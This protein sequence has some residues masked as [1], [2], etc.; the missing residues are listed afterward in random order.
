MGDP[1]PQYQFPCIVPD[2][3]ASNVV[4]LAGVTNN[5]TLE[6]NKVNL[7]NVAA[8]SLK[9][10]AQST[11]T[12]LWARDMALVCD[13]FNGDPY[14]FNGAPIML[15][16]FSGAVEPAAE[17]D[18][19]HT[20]V[21]GPPLVMAVVANNGTFVSTQSVPGPWLIGGGLYSNTG[22][23]GKYIWY[24]GFHNKAQGGRAS[25]WFAIAV[26]DDGSG[27]LYSFQLSMV[28]TTTPLL[29]I[30]TFMASTTLLPA[31]GYLSIFDKKGGGLTYTVSSRA[32]VNN[33]ATDNSIQTLSSPTAIKMNGIM[34]TKDAIPVTMGPKGYIVDKASSGVTI[35]YTIQPSS[36]DIPELQLVNVS[37]NVPPFLRKR[38]STSLGT[39]LVFY[40]GWDEFGSASNNFYVYDT[41]TN[42]WGGQGLVPA[43][44][45]PTNGSGGPG[46]GGDGG[47]TSNPANAGTNLAG[48]IGGSVA[49][50][51]V[52][53]LAF[54]FAIRHRRRYR[55]CLDQQTESAADVSGSSGAGW[56]KGGS[57]RALIYPRSKHRGGRGRARHPQ[58]EHEQEQEQQQQQQEQTDEDEMEFGKVAIQM[59]PVIS[60]PQSLLLQS[61]TLTSNSSL[62]LL[63]TDSSPF[64]PSSLPGPGGRNPQ[65]VLGST[66]LQYEAFFEPRNNP[67]VAIA[68][69]ITTT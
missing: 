58:Q 27:G 41:I 32:A 66:S 56:R 67:Q 55:R 22:A 62:S 10:V 51:V 2:T 24:T 42:S 23:S 36:T 53:A 57:R 18:N 11:N 19:P 13:I 15:S 50:I 65:T 4:F 44:P 64:Q 61:E 63:W 29:S 48:I 40:G 54:F 52:L 12:T 59:T 6:I 21:S 37:G 20:G 9:P 68:A 14:R 30:G 17:E 5:S 8:P 43:P 31:T 3:T 25:A 28:P 46:T 49:G 38:A 16:L 7:A 1:L 33:G 45:I 34:L 69:R 39:Q 35:L 60:S 26:A 47:Q